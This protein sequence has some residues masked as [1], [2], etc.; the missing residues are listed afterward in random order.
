MARR[1]TDSP[2]LFDIPEIPDFSHETR[3]YGSG[4]G[5]VAGVDEAGRGPLAGP[6]VAAAVVLNP[7]AIPDGLN[8]SKKLTAPVRANLFDLI[9]CHAKAIAIASLCARSIDQSD[10]RAASLEAMRRAVSSLPIKVA[11]VLADGRDVPT[12][13]QCEATA[14]IRGDG[15]CLSIAAASIVAKVT[16]DR[17]MERVAADHGAYG[18]DGHKG[19]GTARH[20]AA[21]VSE[22]PLLRMHRYSFA[23]IRQP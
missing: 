9:I 2:L 22:G 12:G 1:H 20:R 17:M 8:D 6:V 19:Y 15:R 23:P 14:L 10:I 7:A 5:V 13:L 16:R 18:F 3:L 11:H 4:C 21:I